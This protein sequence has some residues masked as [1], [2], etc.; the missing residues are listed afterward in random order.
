MYSWIL[1]EILNNFHQDLCFNTLL[2][3]FDV[4]YSF[5]RN[6][7]CGFGLHFYAVRPRT[8]VIFSWGTILRVGTVGLGICNFTASFLHHCSANFSLN[9]LKNYLVLHSISAVI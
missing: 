8:I 2:M 4:E 1:G 3:S 7:K 5:V 9:A 6:L